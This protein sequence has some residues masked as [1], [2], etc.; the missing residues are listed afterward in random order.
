MSSHEIDLA[1]YLFS[2]INNIAFNHIGTV[3]SVG[4][5]DSSSLLNRHATNLTEIDLFSIDDSRKKA[6]FYINDYGISVKQIG[7]SFAF[8]RLQRANLQQVFNILGF[9]NVNGLLQNLDTGVSDFHSG[10][11][12]K[13]NRDWSDFFSQAEFYN[14]MNFLMMKGSPNQGMS[15]NPGDY[16]LEAPRLGFS[17]NNVIIRTFDE[18]LNHYIHNFKIAVRR[19]WIG[20]DSKSEHGRALSISRKAGNSNWVFSTISGTPGSG[21]QSNFPVSDRKTVYYLMIEKTR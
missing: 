11:V 13:R 7:G 19:S 21:W 20:Q 12:A 9:S 18:Y 5:P 16:I 1:K 15:N 3:Q 10:T 2:N 17:I 4:I 6:D 8:N 14:L